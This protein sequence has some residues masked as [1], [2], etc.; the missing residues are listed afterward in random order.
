MNRIDFMHR[1]EFLLLD[2]PAAERQ[3][4]IQ[5]YEDYLDDAG[6]DNEEEVLA[7][8]GTPEALAESIRA[9]LNEDHADQGEFSEN[10]FQN[11]NMR[12]ENEIAPHRAAQNQ[13]RAQSNSTQYDRNA[14]RNVDSTDQTQQNDLNSRYR[15]EKKKS[16]SAG[17]IAL[18][19]I[20]SILAAPIAIPLLFAAGVVLLAMV[21][22]VIV[23][24][25]VFLFVGV[26]LVGAGILALF[27]SVAK[28]FVVPAGAAIALGMSL[29]MIGLG[30]ILTIG[31]GWL[32]LKV[33]PKAFRSIVDF[34]SGKLRRKGEKRV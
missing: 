22:T 16:M 26:V 7:A 24:A 17:M 23:L 21:F 33:F 1:L 20:L 18:I 32:T 31:L 29:V 25:V 11:R 4:A 14:Q 2:I 10:G 34:T 19:V 6:T 3:E 27:V 5:Y 8:L 28:L 12:S 15:K 13:N 30:I 9:G